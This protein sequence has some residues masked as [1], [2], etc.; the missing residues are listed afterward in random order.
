MSDFYKNQN[1]ASDGVVPVHAA[2]GTPVEGTRGIAQG[3]DIQVATR[4]STAPY[5]PPK[6]RKLDSPDTI[7]CSFEECRAFPMKSTG[8]CAGHSRA[9]GLV[10]WKKGGRP[11]AEVAADV[12]TD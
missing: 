6:R 9:L 4:Y 3:G 2:Y 12:N 7:L 5:R 10:D 1:A 11:R 8:Y